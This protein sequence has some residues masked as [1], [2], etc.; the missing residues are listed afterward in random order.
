ME[1][2][3]RASE[4]SE[5]L[6]GVEALGRPQNYS[7]VEDSG[8]RSRAYELRQKLDRY[9]QS[10]QPDALVRIVIPKGS[11]VPQFVRPES[12]PADTTPQPPA[13]RTRAAGLWRH[14]RLGALFIT[15]AFL[16]GFGLA[17]RLL[18][19][20]SAEPRPDSVLFEAWGPLSAPKADVVVCV[21]TYLHLIVRPDLPQSA[22][23]YPAFPDL[24]AEFRTHRPLKPGETL[25]MEPADASVTFGEVSA[26]TIT[27]ATLRSFG[28]AYQLL[29]ERVVPLA[30]IRNR[31]A[32]V[33]GIPQDSAVVSKLLSS[34]IYTV[35][36]RRE[37]DEL[38]IVDRRANPGQTPRFAPDIG[39]VGQPYFVYGLITVLPSEDSVH[40]ERRTVIFSGL[41][42]VGSN[43]AAD[44]FASADKLRDLRERFRRAGLTAFPSAYQVVVRCKYSDGLLLSS[45]YVTHEILKR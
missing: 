22:T 35:E 27:A 17:W 40:D 5:Y 26:A 28:T 37:V 33:I 23:K 32:I 16:V 14:H 12:E 43:G 18:G 29:P 39:K 41:G 15:L 6:I 34:T 44:F 9:Y 3:G 10:D 45:D 31:N 24:Y 11:Y 20:R 36:Y 42:S 7:A 1:F 25:F 13:W 38:A 21:G 30:A 8:V 4:I 19:G 2:S